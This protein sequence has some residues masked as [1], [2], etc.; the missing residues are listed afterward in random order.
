MKNIFYILLLL[1]ILLMACEGTSVS[2]DDGDGYNRQALLENI[3]DN[4]IIPAHNNLLEELQSLK[5]AT[6]NLI[7]DVSQTNLEEVRN[8]WLET[9]KAWQYV[10]MFNIGKAE[11]IF[12]Y[13]KMNTYPS[14]VSRIENN[15]STEDYD[16]INNYNNVSAQGFP[17]IDYMLYGI[18][19]NDQLILQK[20]ESVQGQE[21]KYSNYLEV[22]IENM[23]ANTIEVINY[24]NNNRQSF[25]NSTDNTTTSSLN[26]LTNDF[27]FYYEKGLRANKIGIPA[28]RFSSTPLPDRIEAYYHQEASKILVLEALEACRKFFV[29]EGFLGEITGESLKTYIDYIS[30]NNLSNEILD[31]FENSKNHIEELDNNFVDQIAIDNLKMLVTYDAIQ[32]GVVKLKTDMLSLLSIRVDYIDADGD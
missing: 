22:I 3:T 9:Y 12:Y 28:G 1:S 21:S 24:W 25:V 30:N 17:A 13:Q 26:L 29:G 2:P 14:N 27:I 16:L 8:N 10:E 19:A 15:I 20:Y 11:E 31:V 4:I 5:S 32:E 7:N 18:E 6:D 23:I